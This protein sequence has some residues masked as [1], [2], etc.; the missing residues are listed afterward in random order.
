MAR[1]KKNLG[2]IDVF[3]ISTGAMFSS[4]LFLLPG[5]AA[6]ETGLSAALAYLIAGFLMLPAM[7]SK[8]ELA[9]AMPRAGG[10]YYFL[11]R[12]MGPLMGTIGGIGTWV[13]LVFKSG[14]ALI[15]MG[16]YLAI[17][18]DIPI[19]TVGLVLAAV[20]CVANLVGAKESSGLQRILVGVLLVVVAAFMLTGLAAT[21]GGTA[22]L[23][24]DSPLLLDGVDGLL[25]TVGLVFVS[26]AGLTKVA[27]VAEEV[28]NP[29][30]NIPLGM[31]LSLFVATIAYT[32]GVALVTLLLPTSTLYTDLAPVA[33]A[34]RVLGG[35][36]AT[37]A[38]AATVIAAVAAFASTANA[39][40]MSASRYPLAM[41]RDQLVPAG[42][43]RL[44][45]FGTPTW[46]IVGTSAAIAL[47]VVIFDVGTVAKLA[48]AFQ[49]LLFSLV[50][51]CVIVMRESRLEYYRPGFKS[52]LYPW[53]Q[54]AGIVFPL[55]LIAEMGWVSMLFT[56]AL[57]VA[58][59]V[60]YALYASSRVTRAGAIFHVFERLGRRRWGAL[61]DELRRILH[62]KGLKDDDPIDDLLLRAPVLELV[63]ELDFSEVTREAAELL[64]HRTD[65]PPDE[66]ADVFVAENSIGMM[67]VLGGAAFP[68][69]Q[70]IGVEQPELVIV[71]TPAG[72]SLELDPAQ[73]H[74]IA[75]DPVYV[76]VF[77]LSPNADAARH[78]R[79]LAHMAGRFED[80]VDA[81]SGVDRRDLA[82]GFFD[83]ALVTDPGP[84]PEQD[85]PNLAGLQPA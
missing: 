38:V 20:F 39:G 69:H 34:A 76:F 23:H 24:T 66:L 72:V 78:Y 46:G 48:S 73:A 85:P 81:A 37:F 21:A 84:P 16:A 64:A 10:T 1:L 41:A 61:D 47:C 40:I 6:A 54:I 68:H 59:A 19:T 43:A 70:Y 17:F 77:L 36:W 27:S 9:T 35:D 57:V 52:P 42:F 26:Y 30:R 50:N 80:V 62:E 63:G 25:A 58:S 83:D 4:G 32:V 49:L 15:G 2:L 82:L 31:G 22:T 11:D 75:D 53:V 56:V 45:K 12:A 44:G 33:S 5:L 55:W 71:K 65:I 51:L 74:I 18:M 29:D 7:L 8:A 28:E 67:P 14:F 13:A 3:A 79:I 60:W